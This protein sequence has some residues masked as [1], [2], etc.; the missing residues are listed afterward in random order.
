MTPQRRDSTAIARC[1]RA[2]RRR[3]G[4]RSSALSTHRRPPPPPPLSAPGRAP[5]GGRSWRAA[6]ATAV[7]GAL[8]AP[9]PP[10]RLLDLGAGTGRIG[11]SFVAAGDDYV[12]RRCLQAASTLR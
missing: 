11:R 5:S 10:P 3:P 4:E 12:G 7:L 9:S 6:A 2:W 1:R 8:A